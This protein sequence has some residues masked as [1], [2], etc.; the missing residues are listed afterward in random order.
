M[1]TRSSPWPDLQPELLGLVFKRY[2][3]LADRVRVR[4]VCRTWRGNARLEPL[5]PPLPW[6]ALFDGTFLSIPSGEIHRMPVPS[7]A[8]CHGSVDNWL[9]LVHNNGRC[10][11]M[12]PF[13]KAK[14]Q[15]PDLTTIWRHEMRT[16]KYRYAYSRNSF[17]YKLA[18]PSSVSL[19]PD[20]FFAAF[21]T[22]SFFHGT[23]SIFQPP[24]AT[25]TVSNK[26]IKSIVDIVFFDGKLYALNVYANLFVLE[27][28][29]GHKGMPKISVYH[30]DVAI[31]FPLTDEH[32]VRARTVWFD[33]FEAD[34]TADSC[35]KW[36]IVNTLGG[37]ALF[38]GRC[39]KS[40]PAAEPHV[41]DCIYFI[42]DY[43]KTEPHV[44]P[45]CDSG[46]FNMRNGKITPLLP[47]T[48]VVQTQGGRR[49]RRTCFFP[50]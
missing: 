21:T 29:E 16:V 20:S 35:R 38:V 45:L 42:S 44:D 47:E 2:P 12:N 28:G 15:L 30:M 31:L 40:L 6:V 49:G 24:I 39:S 14:L 32:L 34:L 41:E 5:P 1:G 50:F 13:S 17:L 46:V 19:T 18:V 4:A 3:S 10:S 22:D 11:L 43:L 37:Q 27:I 26:D 23:I 7:G 8:S 25:D 33:V 48:V 9:F 36:K